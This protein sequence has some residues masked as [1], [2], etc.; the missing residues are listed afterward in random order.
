MR[1]QDADT[2]EHE[3]GAPHFMVSSRLV[4]NNTATP[5]EGH[6]LPIERHFAEVD[7]EWEKVDDADK[8]H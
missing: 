8:C 3:T 1:Q 4:I 6:F 5:E 7:R 2:E